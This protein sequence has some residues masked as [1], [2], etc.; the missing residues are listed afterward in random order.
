MRVCLVSAP[1][2][3]EFGDPRP[4]AEE[5]VPRFPLGVLSLASSLEATGLRPEVVDLDDLYGARIAS[6]AGRDGF[7]RDAASRLARAGADVYGFSTICSSYP[8]TLR[9]AAALKDERP[10]CR[11]VLGGPQAS[12]TAEETLEAFRAVDAVVRGEGEATLPALLDALSR[13]DDPATVPGITYRSAN[14]VSSTI[15]A[16]PLA[17][18]DSL[19]LPAFRLHPRAKR[20]FAMPLEAGR[21]CPF[22]CS[23]C[24]TSR[25]FG[26]R[27]RMKSPARIVE[28]MLA[29]REL[30]GV[31]RFE[32]V[33]DNFTV[34]RRR[35]VEFCDAISSAR[36]GLRWSCSSRTDTLDEDLVELMWKAGCRGIFFGIESGSSAMQTAMG[37]R[38]D[39]AGARDLLRRVSRRGLNGTLSFIVGFPDETRQDLRETVAFFVESLRRDHL[40]PQISLLSPLQ[41][42]P[43]QEKHREE[44]IRDEIVSDIAL[45]GD[46]LDRADEELIG[47]HP[48]IFSS[49]YS[50]P[51]RWLDRRE[52]H[53]LRAFLLNGRFELRWLLVAAA[54]MEGDGLSAFEGFRAWRFGGDSHGPAGAVAAYYGGRAFRRDFVRF[55]RVHLS[56]RHPGSGHALRALARYYG[57]L[58]QNPRGPPGARGVARN[59][60]S[61]SA[62]LRVTRVPCDGAALI[63]TLRSAG[64][65]AR[66][67]RRAS[68]IVTRLERDRHEMIQ[69][70]EEAGH[71]LR[72]CDGTRDRRVVVREFAR[73]YPSVRGVPGEHAAAFG[74]E[75]LRQGGL[76]ALSGPR[77]RRRASPGAPASPRGGAGRRRRP[78][79]A[80]AGGR[81]RAAPLRG[82]RAARASGP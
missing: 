51:T 26:R 19:P 4:L 18:L 40:E 71:L 75:A 70:R 1:T 13:S 12:V 81:A 5:P 79:T 80:R 31:R 28:E 36:A 2:V 22:G 59:R 41:G 32:L 30:H 45:Q 50:V 54:Q 62:R 72:L 66:V 16:P 76:V 58:L 27:F 33:H 21:G 68:V 29:L 39:L 24:S 15:D 64:D 6:G 53:E 65:L 55:V 9:I 63:R 47:R 10:G 37:K 57:D 67:P 56:A 20:P 14:G 52:L 44:L 7:A 17:T 73:M 8:L 42:T 23:F 3:A 35:V 69:V 77:A 49:F 11:I 43:I 74:L 34:D 48:G 46:A 60:P 82:G 78:S 25:F 61:I 38:L